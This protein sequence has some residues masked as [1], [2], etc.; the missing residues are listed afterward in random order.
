[1]NIR[2]KIIEGVKKEEKERKSLLTNHNNSKGLCQL[3]HLTIQ[4]HL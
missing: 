4:L 3:E 2:L 1:M